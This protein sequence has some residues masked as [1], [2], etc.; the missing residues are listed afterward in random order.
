MP[1]AG[2]WRERLNT[3]ATVY[4]GSGH[5]N[6]GAIMARA[7]QSHGQPARAEVSLPPMATLIFE[8]SNG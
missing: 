2:R 4:G 1:R 3:D 8:Y 6:L 5:G 7:L